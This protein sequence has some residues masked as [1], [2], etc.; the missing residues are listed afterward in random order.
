MVLLVLHVLETVAL[1]LVMRL[2]VLLVIL[3][4]LRVVLVEDSSIVALRL[5][6]LVMQLVRHVTV[7]EHQLV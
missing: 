6:M 3:E 7:Q 5:A 1:P 4:I 2:V